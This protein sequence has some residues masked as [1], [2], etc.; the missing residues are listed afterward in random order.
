MPYINYNQEILKSQDL[1][2]KK[3]P[4][5]LSSVI[6]Y[7]NRQKNKIYED[8]NLS[9]YEYSF[10]KDFLDFY[11][12]YL[13]LGKKDRLCEI[14]EKIN[15]IIRGASKSVLSKKIKDKRLKRESYL[16]QY[17]A[18]LSLRVVDSLFLFYEMGLGKSK[19]I[20]DA[21]NLDENINKVI[22]VV[23]AHLLTEIAKKIEED[24]NRNLQIKIIRPNL[25]VKIKEKERY[26][27]VLEELLMEKN[28]IHIISYQY[29]GKIISKNKENKDFLEKIVNRVKV[30]DLAVFDEAHYFKNEKSLNYEAV[31]VINLLS[32][33]RIVSTGTP[34]SRKIEET[35]NLIEN[36]LKRIEKKGE[37]EDNIIYIIKKIGLFLKSEFVHNL[38]PLY[39][40]EIKVPANKELKNAFYRVIRESS[41]ESKIQ[42]LLQLNSFFIYKGDGLYK[43]FGLEKINKLVELI[44]KEFSK[45]QIIPIWYLYKAEAEELSKW[46][47]KKLKNYRIVVLERDY[48]NG[49]DLD[50]YRKGQKTILLMQIQKFAEGLNLQEYG[51]NKMIFYNLTYDYVKY[52]QAI[53]RIHRIGQKKECYI[54]ILNIYIDGKAITNVVNNL[55]YKEE[56]AEKLFEREELRGDIDI[57]KIIKVLKEEDLIY[58]KISEWKFSTSLIGEFKEAICFDEKKS[59]SYLKKILDNKNE[60]NLKNLFQ[61]IE[62]KMGKYIGIYLSPAKWESAKRAM[63]RSEECLKYKGFMYEINCKED[64]RFEIVKRRIIP[65]RCKSIICEH[66][67]GYARKQIRTENLAFFE[68]ELYKKY[69]GSFLTLTYKNIYYLSAFSGFEA[70]NQCWN[71]FMDYRISYKDL[72]NLE[73]EGLIEIE[74]HFKN[75][76]DKIIYEDKN[77]PKRKKIRLKEIKK[78]KEIYKKEYK[79]FIS[80]LKEMIEKQASIENYSEEFIQYIKTYPILLYILKKIIEYNQIKIED[81]ENFEIKRKL[82]LKAPRSEKKNVLKDIELKLREFLKTYYK[83]NLNLFKIKNEKKYIDEIEKYLFSF[84]KGKIIKGRET[85]ALIYSLIS[86][87]VES[88][89]VRY[90]SKYLIKESLV[91]FCFG[92]PL[93]ELKKY[94]ITKKYPNLRLTEI[95]QG[96]YRLEITYH[97]G[98]SIEEEYYNPHIHAL[99]VCPITKS[100]YAKYLLIVIARRCGLGEVLDIKDIEVNEKDKQKISKYLLADYDAPT[101]EVGPNRS[102]KFVMAYCLAYMKKVRK[103]G[104]E[105]REQW[106]RAFYK[107]LLE[108]L[109]DF[110]IYC[111]DEDKVKIE[112][113][114]SDLRK[115][116]FKVN[117][118]ITSANFFY[119]GQKVA[120]GYIKIDEDGAYI[121]EPSK[122]ENVDYLISIK[123]LDFYI[124]R[125]L[126]EILKD[127]PPS[128]LERGVIYLK[129][130][131]IMIVNKKRSIERILEK[132]EN[133]EWAYEED[134]VSQK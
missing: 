122:K 22:I 24:L 127:P 6:T 11:L 107:L 89:R 82:K 93:E 100:K 9:I 45:E 27:K 40:K 10:Y 51:I 69:G 97:K 43:T 33:K 34:F 12:K 67:Q 79:K 65:Y 66:C 38:P 13:L 26:Q 50:I 87:I 99:V 129:D 55:N 62:E 91:S 111:F 114:A 74:K 124:I 61:E 20:A 104:K 133:E 116:P 54:Y 134:L 98:K 96:I 84:Y 83:Y 35:I 108:D 118:K 75:I 86:D 120:N 58:R 94:Y 16:Y 37:N 7:L 41:N 31:R 125:T 78:E 39:I 73:Q 36:P 131:K 57:E 25:Y 15:K 119:E 1:N 123:N 113:E 132:S 81:L 105:F 3:I 115:S 29:L 60:I 109:S 121:F 77:N 42:K 70:F 59:L 102:N 90:V 8:Q 19:V 18:S 80:K 23:P 101:I 46:L 130:K 63:F 30:F 126:E 72:E 92:T 28:V 32:E 17:L 5:K 110:Y 56:Q 88:L 112:Y 4:Q 44:K 106:K 117:T 53:K 95:L 71:A 14:Y 68:T 85:L 47:R 48:E 128:Y 2:Q 64:N 76:K 49:V 103:V 52:K 21:I